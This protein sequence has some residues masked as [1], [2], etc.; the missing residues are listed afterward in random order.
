[1][2]QKLTQGFD[3][4]DA[5]E[6]GFTSND[7]E[8]FLGRPDSLLPMTIV[9]SVS[10]VKHN[11]ISRDFPFSFIKDEPRPGVYFHKINRK[12]E[13]QTIWI[14]GPLE[15]VGRTRDEQNNQWGFLLKWNDP[16]QNSHQWLMPASMLGSTNGEEYRKQLLSGGLE[17]ANTNESRQQLPVYIQS[18]PSP[19]RIRCSNQTGWHGQ[20]YVF[21]HKTLGFSSEQWIYKNIGVEENPYSTKGTSEEWSKEIGSLCAGNS[22]LILSVC[23]AFASIL[24]QHTGSE[25]AGIHLV[26][27]SSTGKSTAAFLAG[28]IFGGKTYVQRWNATI[29]GLEARAALHNDALLILDEIGQVDPRQAGESAYMLANGLGRARA[30]RDGYFRERQRWRLLLLSTGECDLEQHMAEGGK[31]ARAGQII[32]LLSIPADTGKHGIFEELHGFE[33]GAAM[34]KVIMERVE[35]YHGAIGVNFIEMVAKRD[36]EQICHDIKNLQVT[37]VNEHRLGNQSGQV[38]RAIHFFGLIAAT[39]ELASQWGLTTWEPGAALKGVSICFNAWLQRR[40]GSREEEWKGLLAQIRRYLE[41]HG[42]SRFEPWNAAP[43]DKTH[44]RIGF[45]KNNSEGHTTYYVLPEGF[46][47][48]LCQGYDPLSA[49]R[50]L[51]EQGYLESDSEGKSS[52]SIRTPDGYQQRVYVFRPKIFE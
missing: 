50:W 19:D 16:D 12:G 23:T 38:E 49:A 4:A 7:F 45:C 25:N 39:G 30:N 34:S 10:H 22:R 47:Q 5:L 52:Q 36:N 43:D 18:F 11:E 26:G 51:L 24:L 13:A 40:G 27:N 31:K 42:N 46:K 3:A 35:Q 21:P 20:S 32:R 37:F 44:N 9:D 8:E 48:E 14:C 33:N 2:N 15:V 29:N 1:M 6:N 17:I 28:S 41:A